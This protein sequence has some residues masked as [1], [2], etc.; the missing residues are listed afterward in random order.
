[1]KISTGIMIIKIPQN[2][3]FLLPN[4]YLTLIDNN[5]HLNLMLNN[6]QSNL[7]W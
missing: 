3:K 2:V 6:F 4:S 5:F 7:S 1:M